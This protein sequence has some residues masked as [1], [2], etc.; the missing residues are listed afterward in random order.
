MKGTGKGPHGIGIRYGGPAC[1]MIHY[2]GVK[3]R[4]RNVLAS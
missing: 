2:G 3:E 1:K 4:S